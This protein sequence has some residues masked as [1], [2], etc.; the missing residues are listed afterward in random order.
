MKSID[1]QREQLRQLYKSRPD[2]R[3]IILRQNRAIELAEEK[4]AKRAGAIT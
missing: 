2:L 4:R 1:E 3:K